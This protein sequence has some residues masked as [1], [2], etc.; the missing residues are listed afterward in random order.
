[1]KHNCPARLIIAFCLVFAFLLLLGCSVADYRYVVPSEGQLKQWFDGQ[2]IIVEKGTLWDTKWKVR[3]DQFQNVSVSEV[4]Q[5]DVQAYS[6]DFQDKNWK[7]KGYYY[8]ATVEFT[9]TE[10]SKALK[11]RGKMLYVYLTPENV[12]GF[13][14]FNPQMVLKL[15]NW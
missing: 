15:G 3:A 10:G 8:T 7:G 1:M 11:V 9:L 5:G 13:E 4:K 6:K 2:E 14:E 12:I